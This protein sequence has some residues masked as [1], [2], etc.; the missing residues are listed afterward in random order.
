MQYK[1]VLES[2]ALSMNTYELIFLSVFIPINMINFTTFTCCYLSW[3]DRCV[4]VFISF[5]LVIFALTL[6]RSESQF[7]GM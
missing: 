3:I 7:Q 4:I 2:I 6:T 5:S 1:Y